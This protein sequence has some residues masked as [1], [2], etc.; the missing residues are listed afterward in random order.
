V[1][2]P[3][4]RFGPLDPEF[5]EARKLFAG[6]Q[7]RVHRQPACRQPITL[8]FADGTE[9]VRPKEHQHLVLVARRVHRE[10]HAKAGKACGFKRRRVEVVATVIEESGIE[11]D[12]AH[13]VFA[14]SLMRTAA[15]KLDP[16]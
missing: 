9:I 12:L 7:R 15:S 14:T 13:A 2:F 5:L 16:A 1:Q 10:V 6:T 3:G 4:L 8:T 11:A